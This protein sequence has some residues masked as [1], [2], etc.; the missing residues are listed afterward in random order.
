M[1]M[2]VSWWTG[3]LKSRNTFSQMRA[4][5]NWRGILK[6]YIGWCYDKPVYRGVGWDLLSY[7]LNIIAT[8]LRVEESVGSLKILLMSAF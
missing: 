6:T 7:I 8:E 5:D 2:L 4:H 1:L 3:Y